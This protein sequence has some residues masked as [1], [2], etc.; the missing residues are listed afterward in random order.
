MRRVI[1]YLSVGF[2]AGYIFAIVTDEM[3][4]PEELGYTGR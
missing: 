4:T 2:V 1:T 3:P